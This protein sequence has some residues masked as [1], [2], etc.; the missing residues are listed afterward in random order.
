M[1]NQQYSLDE[2]YVY[3]KILDY[4]NTNTLSTYTLDICPLT[5]VPDFTTSD[6]FL[7]DRTLSNK[8]IKWDFGD[9]TF[10]T[11]LTAV[12][13]YTWPGEYQ[14]KLTMFDKFGTP[15]ESSYKPVV[16]I[17][18]YLGDDLLWEDYGKFVY[19]VPAGKLGDPLYVLTRNSWQSYNALSATGITI[20]LYASGAAGEYMTDENYYNDKWSHLRLLSRFYQ[21]QRFGEIEELVF[22]D[23]ITAKTEEIYAKITST[24]IKVCNKNDTG[25]ILVGVTGSNEIFYI[26]DKVKNYTTRENPIFLVA[27]F[28]ASRF[29]DAF[30]QRRE[31][32][33]YIDYPPASFQNFEP[34]FL[35]IIKVRHNPAQRF[36]ITTT[37][38]DGEG[39][40]STTT[41]KLPEISWQNTETPFLLKFKDFEGF[42]T[43]T[44]QPLSSSMVENVNN[45]ATPSA[46]NVELGII[47]YIDNSTFVP[48]TGIRWYQDFPFDAPQSIGGFYKGYFTSD[49]SANN[50]VLTAA[51]VVV[52]PANFPKDTLIAWV[53]IPQYSYV[54]RIFRQQFY[55]SCG[56]SVTLVL[57]GTSQFVKTNDNRQIYSIS[58]AP[59]GAGK[60]NDYHTWLA[61]SKNDVIA[62]YSLYGQLLSS[63]PLSG[64]PTLVNDLVEIRDYRL[65]QLSCA[66]P[67]SIALDS[68]SDLWVSLFDSGKI[69]KIN[70]I[71]GYVTAVAEPPTQN[72]VYLASSF[73]VVPYLSGF[74]G[75][76]LFL[77]AS[78][79]T[80]VENNLWAA[81]T[82]PVSSVL[83]K[84]GSTGALLST[85]T[86]PYAV[87]P[88][89]ICIDRD[90]FI[91]VTTFNHANSSISLTGRND[92]LYKFSNEGMLVEG[93]PLTGFRM[94]NN[95][96]VD[97]SQN[98]WVSHDRETITKIDRTT[99]ERTD[100]QAGSGF[101]QTSYICSINGITSDTSDF[102][103]VINDWD[104][105]IYIINTYLPPQSA[106]KFATVIDLIYPPTLSSYPVSAFEI[107]Q[108]QAY[109]DWFG[110]RW[111]NKYMSPTAIIRTVTGESSMFNIY[112][113]TGINN[114]TK[115][116]EDWDAESFYKS[117]RYQEVLLDKE[118][119]FTTF[120][121]GILGDLKS[122]PYELGKTV[123]EKIA[124]FVD[125]KANIG[126]C[127]LQTLIAFCNEL[128]IPYEEYNYPFPPQLER[129]I[130]I[131]SIKQRNL[132]GDKNLYSE[133]F[134]EQQPYG[135]IKTNLGTKISTLTGYVSSGQPV[136]AYEL[137]SE[138][139]SLVN[140]SQ[141]PG[142]SIGQSVPLSSYSYDWGWGLVVP[143]SVSGTEINTYYNFY[144]FIPA[145]EGSYYN[146]IINWSDSLTTLQPSNSSY[147]QWSRDD[148]IM[149]TLISY[150]LTKGLR[151]F[152]SA[153]NI[154]YNN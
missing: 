128:T 73:G 119:L 32:F 28:D 116:N 82:H 86:F 46:Y 26:D 130:N 18:N 22:V 72:F 16:K 152:T 146:N 49:T 68:N 88:V 149:Q 42:T 55:D 5:F 41:F 136:V 84:Y 131:L 58:V 110:F 138:N 61:D 95:I 7:S 36:S 111:V 69:I 103:W 37:G 60:G 59:S 106:F 9:D 43:K 121:G 126:T 117:L 147:S 40:L 94:L 134:K 114:I 135:N 45:V 81:Y 70:G 83:V 98:A 78:I 140:F 15:L 96:T 124:N 20:N 33:N 143:R 107:E 151:L 87:S 89:E 38:I 63:I 127:N 150:E 112:P 137:F 118:A 109:G 120:L 52:D 29:E 53:A 31:I 145:Q 125:N 144:T 132:W 105:K 39:S 57:T 25:S 113:D 154:T 4:A 12:H 62:K 115:V 6:L 133:N 47:S 148:G 76:G 99:G 13:S 123:Y 93:Y 44:Y 80:D 10:S 48:I 85:I 64:A 65:P 142:I 101:N 104:K 102:I 51:A 153:A 19:D 100:F 90:K 54:Q 97:G 2:T 35:P 14:V 67:N 75:E 34:A 23:S 139:Y 92:L 27:S 1:A 74:A 141:I 108:F 91:W 11:D 24:D 79:D 122:Q 3:F 8:A 21:K 17:Y 66:S 30:A 56:G 71:Q 50:C 129:L 77:P